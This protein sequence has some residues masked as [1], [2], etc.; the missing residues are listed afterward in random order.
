MNFVN[1]KRFGPDTYRGNKFDPT[2]PN[3]QLNIGD[4]AV[5]A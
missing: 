4:N 1:I 2:R 5:R 3:P